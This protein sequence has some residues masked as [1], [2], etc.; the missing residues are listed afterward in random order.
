VGAA[1]GLSLEGFKSMVEMQFADFVTMGF[2][3]IVNNLA[4]IH[5][6]W[7]QNADVVIRMPTGGGVGAGPFHSQSNEAW[8]VH[9]PGLKVVYPSIPADAKGL[10]IAAINDPNPVLYFE[11]KALYRSV[12]GPVPEEYYE[13]EIGKARQVQTGEDLSII[14]YGAG[15][16]WAEDYAA[17][18]TD[19]SIDIVD[20]RTLLPLDY[21]AIAASVKRTGKVL[22]LHE[23]TL[24][25]GIG[26]EIA[27][28]ISEHCFEYL[29]APIMRCASLDTAVPFNT[30]LENNFLAKARLG[31]KV[32]QLMGY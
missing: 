18:H 32:E 6:R 5:Y 26:G 23:D 8:F 25:G 21:E 19:I 14:T 16:H 12:S 15:V 10:L 1:L 20:L 22:L 28:W 9:T 2:N 24:I 13:I 11:H 7:G 4:K 30:E 29:D 17:E 3:Q 31:E 27:A